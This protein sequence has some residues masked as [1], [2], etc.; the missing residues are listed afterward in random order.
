MAPIRV[1]ILGPFD[2]VE[3]GRLSAVLANFGKPLSAVVL[4][5]HNNLREAF[6]VRSVPDRDDC[7]GVAN[8]C[9]PCNE[10]STIGSLAQQAWRSL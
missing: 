10:R 6:A 1:L 7:F 5:V 9:V 2:V 3:G 4:A 8:H